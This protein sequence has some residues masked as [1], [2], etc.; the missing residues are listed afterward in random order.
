MQPFIEFSMERWQS[1]YENRVDYNLSESGV[2]PMTLRELLDLAR[3]E[4]VDDTLV[5]YGQSNGSDELRARIAALYHGAS[6]ANV[7]ATNGSAE[8]N[9]VALWEL[10]E[11]GDEVAIVTPAYGQTL[12]LAPMLGA[13]VR[14]IPLRQELGWQ[15]DPD[16]VAR[17][18]TGR[19]KVLVIT[20][21]S[22]PTG[23]IL[24]ADSRAALVAAASRAGAWIVADE[25]Y[26]GAEL[27][28]PETPSFFGDYERVLA[29]GSLSK[30]Y[31]LP[32]LRVGWVVA[33][34]ALAPRLWARTDYTTISTGALT[35]RLA[36][37]ALRA[38]VRPLVLH[39]TRGILRG[40]LEVLEH[41]LGDAGCFSYLRPQAGAIAWVRYDL[42]V[43]SS[44]LAERLRAE[45]SV[46]VVPGD[47]FGLDHFLRIGYG[48][49]SQDLTAALERV[50]KVLDT[51]HA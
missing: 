46:L 6:D 28:P 11:P 35:D 19:T 49:L 7:V 42:P 48:L 20:N 37:L 2:H 39:R 4:S 45:Q 16:D 5:G 9:F 38:D 24:T 25:V 1:T 47:H 10:V 33:P 23:A 31:G 22:N 14:P 27:E 13:T 17:G 30:A 36:A 21:P 29:T 41:W 15:P 3:V 50:K 18:V 51:P 26:T 8:A 12:G 34:T 44:R 32:G 43:N 40:S